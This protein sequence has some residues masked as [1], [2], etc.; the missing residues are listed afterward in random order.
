MNEHTKTLDLV[1]H[2]ENPGLQKVEVGGS[3]LQSHSQTHSK[4][5]ANL[6]CMSPYLNHHH[7]HHHCHHYHNYYHHQHQQQQQQPQYLTNKHHFSLTG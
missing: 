5:E 6:H 3:E 1:T 2:F 4:L 7:H